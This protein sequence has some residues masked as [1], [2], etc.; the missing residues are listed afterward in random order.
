MACGERRPGRGGLAAGARRQHG[1]VGGGRRAG[2]VGDEGQRGSAPQA[3]PLG[4]GSEVQVE[5]SFQPGDE[6]ECADGA[7]Y[8]GVRKFYAALPEPGKRYVVRVTVR[9]SVM[10]AGNPAV[11]TGE[12]TLLL[13]G[14]DN[15][16]GRFAPNGEP[17]F[18][19]W[20]F[21]KV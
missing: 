15:P 21:R 6:V 20:R 1:H 8:D 17:G 16:K 9:R 7:F 13:E 4:S 11:E 5:V 2:P 14:L 3:E 12:E 19:A 18:A 10:V